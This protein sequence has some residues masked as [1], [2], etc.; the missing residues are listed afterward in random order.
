MFVVEFLIM[1]VFICISSAIVWIM[2]GAMKY[3]NIRTS[4]T[5]NLTIT[6]VYA[7][8]LYFRYGISI[9]AIQGMLILLVLLWASWSDITSH[10]VG[11]YIWIMISMLGL[12]SIETVGIRSML[13]GAAVVFIPQFTLALI[14]PKKAFGGA[15][16]KISAAIAFLLGAPRG[17]A[18]YMI[19][20]IAAVVFETIY[21]KVKHIDKNEAFPLVPFLVAGFFIVYLI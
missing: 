16:I 12:L 4:L 1:A 17:I 20:L 8:L 18:A 21:L 6:A 13:I 19:G 2:T 11:D 10:E 15:D 9:T 7:G 14:N 3:K 5:V